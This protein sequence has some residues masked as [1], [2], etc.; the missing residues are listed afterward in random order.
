[1]YLHTVAETYVERRWGSQQVRHRDVFACDECGVQYSLGHKAAHATLGSLTFCSNT[2]NKKSRS[3]GKLAQQ[4]KQTKLDRYGVGHSSQVPGA[5]E[6]MI[7]TRVKRTGAAGPAAK[8]S[9]SNRRWRETMVVRHGVEHPSK[10]GDIKEKKRLTYQER[11]GV[12]NPFCVG[13]PFRSDHDALS[14]AGQRGYRSTT[15]QSNGWMLSKP[16]KLLVEFLRSRYKDVRQQVPVEHGTRK[17]WLIDAYVSDTQTYVELDGM[18]WHGLDKPYER[19]HLRGRA[20]YDRDRAQDEWF[21]AEGHRLVRVTDE[22]VLMCQ[23]LND[24]SLILPRLEG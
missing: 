19:L 9:S 11:Y 3:S 17:P 23:E 13:S 7:V 14:E 1:M 12:D 22:E 24:W 8:V 18:F 2:C 5:T 16:E 15:R 21:R 20:A 10:S 4:W 6:K